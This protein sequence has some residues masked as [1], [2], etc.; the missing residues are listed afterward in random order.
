MPGI[1]AIISFPAFQSERTTTSLRHLK[2]M[3]Y[4][5]NDELQIILYQNSSH[6]ILSLRCP[7]TIIGFQSYVRYPFSCTVSEMLEV[8]YDTAK[9][10]PG[11]LGLCTVPRVRRTSRQNGVVSGGLGE[12]SLD[13]ENM[14]RTPVRTIWPQDLEWVVASESVHSD[15]RPPKYI[16]LQARLPRL[17]TLVKTTKRYAPSNL[18]ASFISISHNSGYVQYMSSCHARSS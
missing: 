10:T 3:S 5:P 16:P 6:A 2:P 4:L 1:N 14:Y 8:L 9:P 13:L 18:T 11:I 15:S 17:T 7:N 12:P